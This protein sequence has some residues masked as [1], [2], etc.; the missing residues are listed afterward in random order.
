MFWTALFTI[1]RKIFYSPEN[2]F[3]NVYIEKIK[4]VYSASAEKY[5][6]ELLNY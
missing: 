1:P 5:F 6:T 4:I 2:L 3:I